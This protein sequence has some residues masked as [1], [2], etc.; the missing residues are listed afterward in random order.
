MDQIDMEILKGLK[1]G[2]NQVQIGRNLKLSKQAVS[3]RV[4]IMK[5]KGIEIPKNEINDKILEGLQKGKT[6]NE[7][8]IELKVSLGTVSKRIRDMK[9]K[10]I[11][12]PKSKSGRK[13]KK[14]NDEIDNKILEGLQKGKTQL[15]MAKKLNLSFVTISKRIKKMKERGIEIP[16]S[17]RGRKPK[18]E[19]DEIDNKILE[20]LQKGETQKQ[21]GKKVNVT[22]QTISKRIKKMKKRGVEV[23]KKKKSRKS[24]KE[25]DE[26]NNKKLAEM[27]VKLI[28]DKKGTKEQALIM[29]KEYGVEIYVSEL[30]DLLINSKDRDDR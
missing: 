18:K 10:G 4:K 21:I 15:E 1:E 13:P 20:E 12:I 26:I 5:E 27:I 19:N 17:K 14:E 6:Q 7:I 8:A 24:K 23:P 22:Q 30:W 25:N 29:G 28:L 9:E 3:K 11:E 2:K 16:K